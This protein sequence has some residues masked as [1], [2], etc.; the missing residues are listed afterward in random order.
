[1][2]SNGTAASFLFCPIPLA[3]DAPRVEQWLAISPLVSFDTLELRGP[4][5][6]EIAAGL[7]T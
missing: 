4:D 5:F 7:L 2:D 3:L 6:L 1:V